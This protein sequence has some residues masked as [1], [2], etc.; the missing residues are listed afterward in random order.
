L[1]KEIRRVGGQSGELWTEMLKKKK[2]NFE[3]LEE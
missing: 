3:R 2:K 1:H